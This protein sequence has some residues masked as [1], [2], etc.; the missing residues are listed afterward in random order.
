MKLFLTTI[1]KI[2]R[3]AFPIDGTTRDYN[4]IRIDENGEHRKIQNIFESDQDYK[5]PK[6]EDMTKLLEKVG[7][8]KGVKYQAESF[9]CDDFALQTYAL[10]ELIRPEIAFGII[11]VTL[12]DSSG[13]ALN[14]FIDD[15]GKLWYYEP[16]DGRVFQNDNYKPY[17]LVV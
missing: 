2:V 11:W 6:Y 15:A 17:L 13:H 10:L 8:W 14:F 9:D 5:Y 12:P 7:I 3:L 1:I 16:Q 4:L